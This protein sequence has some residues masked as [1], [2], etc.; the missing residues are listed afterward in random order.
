MTRN[1]LLNNIDHKDLR[2]ISQR[3]AAYGDDVMCVVTYPA[4][5]RNVAAHYPIIFQK[6]PDGTTFI[7]LALFG[8]KD[9]QNLFLRDDGRW[10]AY[11]LP[12]AVERLPFLIGLDG[13]EL[14]VHVDL[15]S[16]KV[17]ATE[18]EPVFLPFGGNTEYLER[19]SSVLLALHEGV[20]TTKAF[21][22]ALLANELLEPLTLDIEQLDGSVYRWA[23]FYTIHEERLQKLGAQ[24]LG[25]LNDAGFLQP[26][27]MAVA[28]VSRFRDLIERVNQAGAAH[29]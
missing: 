17:S 12:L 15:D 23:G 9:K 25:Q 16:P 1:V 11:Y 5:F 26:I 13:Q 2:V 20:Q 21:V 27:Y 19:I 6:S 8:F 28:S 7:P 10:D 29:R 22:A 18:G 14:M 4:E 24:A 3:G